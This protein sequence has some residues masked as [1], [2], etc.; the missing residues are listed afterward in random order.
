MYR[1]ESLKEI[2]VLV[3]GGVAGIS[4]DSGTIPGIWVSWVFVLLLLGF[5]FFCAGELAWAIV[6]ASGSISWALVWG[7]P[8]ELQENSQSFTLDGAIWHGLFALAI[9]LAFVG[10]GPSNGEE[11]CTTVQGKG[12]RSSSIGAGP[13]VILLLPEYSVHLFLFLRTLQQ[14]KQEEAV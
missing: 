14:N 7:V 6:G 13:L 1:W 3:A 4:R 11:F 9:L 5:R 12:R 10:I 8:L 2:S